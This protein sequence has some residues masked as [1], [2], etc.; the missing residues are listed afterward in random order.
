MEMNE[1]VNG[2]EQ[3]FYTDRQAGRGEA[4]RDEGTQAGIHFIDLLKE[5]TSAGG[6]TLDAV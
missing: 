5:S 3:V 6:W 2:R 1:T 4:E